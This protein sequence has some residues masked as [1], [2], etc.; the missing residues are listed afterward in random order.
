MTK[1]T[2]MTPWEQVPYIWKTES[3]FM[4]WVRGGLRAGIWAKHPIKLEYIKLNR[5]KVKNPNPNGRVATVWGME[6]ERCK[7]HFPCTLPKKLKTSLKAQG[8][9]SDTIQIDHKNPA[10]SLKTKEDVG[11]FAGRLAWVTFE[12]LRPLCKGCHDIITYAE[13]NNVSE[14]EAVC[15]KAAIVCCG[16]AISEQKEFLLKEGFSDV[17]NAT[18]RRLAFVEYYRKRT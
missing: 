10:G 14:A 11:D 18:S 9:N 3:A 12:D 7:G 8:L 16:W 13:K 15:Q 1:G 2:K 5:I 4:S 17:G 6:C